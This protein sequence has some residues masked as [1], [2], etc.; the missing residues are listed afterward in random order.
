MEKKIKLSLSLCPISMS[1]KSNQTTHSL[2][3]SLLP[4]T[5]L[6]NLTQ[7]NLRESLKEELNS[8]GNIVRLKETYNS[9]FPLP[10]SKDP[11]SIKPQLAE[12]KTTYNGLLN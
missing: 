12:K 10:Y 5:D 3:R 2:M 1:S 11:N 8:S 4:Q 7:K 9:L 6:E